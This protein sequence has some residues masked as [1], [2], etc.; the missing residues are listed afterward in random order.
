MLH[1][2]AYRV[3]EL[4]EI[5]FSYYDSI[6]HIIAGVPESQFKCEFSPN[7]MDSYDINYEKYFSPVPDLEMEYSLLYNRDNAVAIEVGC[8]FILEMQFNGEVS[9]RGERADR[10]SSAYMPSGYYPFSSTWKYCGLVATK[11]RQLYFNP[12][13]QRLYYDVPSGLFVTE[14]GFVRPKFEVD[15]T[16]YTFKGT[17]E[18]YK[19]M[20]D[21]GGQYIYLL[22][23]GYYILNK[24]L[25]IVKEVKYEHRT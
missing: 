24:E 13:L 6:S 20:V 9:F 21:L 22:E 4:G 18:E 7:Q 23:D 1:R 5:V 12:P 17:M 2:C 11:I 14:N 25:D 10:N 15:L 19:E 3:R 8:N 16:D